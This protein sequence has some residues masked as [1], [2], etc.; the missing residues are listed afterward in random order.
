MADKYYIQAKRWMVPYFREGPNTVLDLGC[1]AGVLGKLLMESGRL[2]A[3]DGVELFPSAA[4]EAAKHYRKVHLGDIEAMQFDYLSEFDYVVCGDILEH[5][6]DPYTVLTKI[7]SWLKPGGM[8]LV[9]LPNVRS[10]RVL[11]KLVFFG[12][13]EY[14]SAGILDRTHLRFFTRRS[15]ERMLRDA[16]FDVV[17]TKVLVEGV[18]KK[19]FNAFT[20]GVFDEFLASQV[21]LCGQRR[22]P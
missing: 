14:V 13:W 4:M 2:G 17:D 6:K 1:A 7:H 8:I 18:K 12:E 11:T 5:L 22:N 16:Y 21:F 15:A 3:I 20:F 19:V 9:C 10:Y